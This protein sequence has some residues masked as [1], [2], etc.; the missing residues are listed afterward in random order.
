MASVSVAD[1]SAAEGSPLNFVVS[2]SPAVEQAV[3][4]DY[5]TLDGTA[6]AGKDYEQ[7][8][9]TLT[10]AP[11]ETGKTVSVNTLVESNRGREVRETV[12]LK[13]SNATGDA[14]IVKDT[15]VGTINP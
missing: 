11:G 13:L 10:F 12:A 9:G 4:V 7:T 2:L 3:T 14:T 15:A 6:R 5:R 8:S 1:A